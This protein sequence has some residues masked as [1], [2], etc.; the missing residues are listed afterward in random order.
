M[1]TVHFQPQIN[2]VGL[3]GR[4]K[5]WDG[6]AFDYSLNGS[7]GTLQATATYKFPGV[8]F[9]GFASGDYISI[10]AQTQ[11]D[12]TTAPLSIFA[13]IHSKDA[14]SGEIISRNFNSIATIQYHLR[15]SQLNFISCGL[16]G[17]AVD[18]IGTTDD[19][20]INTW[21]FAG[22]TWDGTNVKAFVNALQT[23][24]DGA[25]SAS[26]TSRANLNIARRASEDYF[27]GLIDDV[28]IFNKA[29]SIAEI[30]SIYET[31]RGRY[32]V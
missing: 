2:T 9:G 17:G 11:T 16:E 19:A 1:K 13:W 3:V 18:V 25:Y 10:D 21:L 4:W 23:G 15:W 22:F 27:T 6:T 20:P 29:L 26:L 30:K 28:I 7:L 12:I 8:E 31:T 24:S 5:L 14:D 32:G